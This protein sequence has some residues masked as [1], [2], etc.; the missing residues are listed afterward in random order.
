[1]QLSLTNP[2]GTITVVTAAAVDGVTLVL[3]GS[4]PAAGTD[5]WSALTDIALGSTCVAAIDGCH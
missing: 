1:M 4:G 2:D 5:K 3:S